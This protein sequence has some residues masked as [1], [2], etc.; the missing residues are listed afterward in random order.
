ML[1]K[2]VS[3]FGYFS[4]VKGIC[5]IFC[6]LTFLPVAAWVCVASPASVTVGCGDG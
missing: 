3:V 5:L 2:S 4:L 6:Q 1:R